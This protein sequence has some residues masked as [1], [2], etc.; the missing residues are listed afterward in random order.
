MVEGTTQPP[1]PPRRQYFKRLPLRSPATT[2][3]C[4]PQTVAAEDSLSPFTLDAPRKAG[5]PDRPISPGIKRPQET[6]LVG[7]PLITN[8]PH[9]TARIPRPS[10]QPVVQVPKYHDSVLIT[11]HPN[12]VLEH[13]HKSTVICEATRGPTVTDIRTI[14]RE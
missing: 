14:K 5:A 8:H 4:S 3:L 1:P 2:P 9:R 11:L 10:K 12:V 13:S 6:A 7:H